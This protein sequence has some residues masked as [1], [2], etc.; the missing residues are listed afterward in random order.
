MRFLEGDVAIHRATTIAE[1]LVTCKSRSRQAHGG[2]LDGAL[3]WA[4]DGALDWA[5]DGARDG[6]RDEVCDW[7]ERTV[8][9][10][11][12]TLRFRSMRRAAD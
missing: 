1:G 6:A 9:P 3:D 4:L 10:L 7:V 11:R 8:S 12:F 5:L 2:A